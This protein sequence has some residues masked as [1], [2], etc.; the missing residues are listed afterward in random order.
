MGGRVAGGSELRPHLVEF[1][2]HLGSAGPI[3][4]VIASF[5]KI[6]LTKVDRFGTLAL[7]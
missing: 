2:G 1:G 3:W 4:P 6:K 5:P 7:G